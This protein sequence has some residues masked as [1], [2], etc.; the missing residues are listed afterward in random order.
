MNID[1]GTVW[2]KQEDQFDCVVVVA[3]KLIYVLFE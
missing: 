2:L 3:Y 1:Y